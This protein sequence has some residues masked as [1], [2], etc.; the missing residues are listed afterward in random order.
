MR[1]HSET[2]KA[3]DVFASRN[4]TFH[5]G[6]VSFAKELEKTKIVYALYGA[7][8]GLSISYSM[9]K[10]VFDI[11][12]TNNQQSSSDAMHEWM[13]SPSGALIAASEAVVLIGFS[14]LG[15]V[16]KP[17]DGVQNKFNTFKRYIAVLWPYCRDSLKG[18]KNAYKGVRSAFQVANAFVGQDLN[19]L[20]LPTGLLLGGISVLN[21]IWYRSVRNERKGINKAYKKILEQIQDAESLDKLDKKIYDKLL[22][23]QGKIQQQKNNL[24]M[25]VLSQFYSGFIDSL[26]LYMGVVGAASMAPP[27]F[28]TLSV[29]CVIIT[30]AC[31]ASRVYEEFEAQRELK[32]NKIK[33]EL[34]LCSKELK[35][36]LA[37]LQVS[38]E[39]PVSKAPKTNRK[40][41]KDILNK[42]IEKRNELE[43][44][45]N[46]SYKSAALS[47][48]RDGLAAYS[49]ITSM[50]FAAATIYAMSFAAFPAFFVIATVALG[51]ACLVGF[52]AYALI[53][54]YF[55][56]NHKPHK[57]KFGETEKQIK[58]YIARANELEISG[59]Y[60]AIDESLV[61]DASPQFFFQEWFEVARSFFSGVGK[62]QKSVDYTFNSWQER[63]E[64][65]HYHDTPV[66]FGLACLSS[67]VF[68]VAL[69]LRAYVRGF[70]DKSETGNLPELNLAINS[71]KQKE[72]SGETQSSGSFLFSFTRFSFFSNTKKQVKQIFVDKPPDNP[73]SRGIVLETQ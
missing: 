10:Y 65:G 14:L 42:F 20:I 50:M 5:A 61:L 7:L 26:Y 30:I 57:E 52:M 13:V 8:D 46:L 36:R 9:V 39:Q 24:P 45:L 22:E 64:D 66:M 35:E 34:V 67:T 19:F 27:V 68:A 17:D 72:S 18:L 49:V 58:D 38:S 56:L 28:I 73:E 51:M 47:G 29:C 2:P 63:D 44:E 41:L 37:E 70:C 48:L 53:K 32:V 55:H 6:C 40:P 69:A 43:H 31:I 12:C 3:N 21:R 15:N 60:K 11:L 62:G 59:S 25:A 33:T 16:L 54:N 71:S 4:K 23:L 1:L